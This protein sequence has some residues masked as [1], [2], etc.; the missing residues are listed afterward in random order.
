MFASQHYVI[1]LG[2]L[3]TVA[4]TSGEIL[5]RGWWNHTVFYQVY[6]RSFMDANNDGVGDL[7]GITDKLEHF[8]NSGVG[9]IWLSPIYKSPMVDFGYDIA[10]FKDID[11]IFGTLADFEKLVARAKQLGLK[12]ILDF[13]PNY[14]S[15]QHFWFQE[16][17]K[18]N[19][20]YADY[21]IWVDG[22]NDTP[23]SNWLSV[24]SNSAW[25]YNTN[26][27]QWYL[28]QFHSKQPDLNCSNP[29][30][31]EEMREILIYWLRKG[32]DGFRMDAMPYLFETNYTKDELRSNKS[33]ATENDHEY[34]IHTL[35]KDLPETYELVLS[36]RKILDEY[37]HQ[38]NTSEKVMMTEAYATLDNTI[39]YYNYGSHIPFNFD[40]IMNVNKTSTASE[41]KAV[42]DNWTKAMPEG[43]VANWVMGN[44]DRARTASRFPGRA[45]Q[46]TM[47]AMILPGVAVTYYGEEIGMVDKSDISW[48]DTQ[49]PQGC[50]AG[51]DKYA[52]RSRDP[53]RTPF[54][55]NNKQNAGFSTAS[56]T[57]IPVHANYIYVNVEA[58][59][60]TIDS[61][62]NVYRA[63]TTLRNTSNALK[64][65]SLTTD[66]I[67]D[68]VLHVLRKTNGEAVS[69]L[70]NFSDEDKKEVTLTDTL[71]GNKAAVIVT[72]SVGSGITKEQA[73]ELNKFN[74]P[75]KASVVILIHSGA[76]REYV[77]SFQII[78]F[79]VVFLILTLYK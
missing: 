36:W 3:L 42:I 56:K 7:Q 68:T 71:P 19:G 54:Q 10:D 64:F 25:S 45:D 78:L 66:I 12:V 1:S 33:D 39:K 51:R 34:L 73:V 31:Q 69:L 50:N 43:S 16:S 48:E 41:F 6:P 53:A 57:W 29:N 67:S 62:Y 27:Q 14:T 55:W 38:Y 52:A 44:H 35:T 22:K 59:Y 21:Y 20:K 37:A 63:L 75:A 47:L 58:Q 18:R 74:V 72:A 61:H 5:D 70:I 2:L 46:M 32:V 30:V 79:S 76:S 4:V 65:G 15:D 49:D 13:A 28:H 23:P 9:A 11:Q 60:D 77:A 26:R 17:V 8:V 40:F 24:F